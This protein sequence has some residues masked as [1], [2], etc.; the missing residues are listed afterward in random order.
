MRPS[1]RKTDGVSSLF[2]SSW[3][4]EEEVGVRLVEF[5]NNL[6][7]FEIPDLDGVLGTSAEPVG[8]GGEAEGVDDGSSF[9]RVQVLALVEIPEHGSVVLTTR[10]TERSVRRNG[11]G[12]DVS[13]VSLEVG[14]QLAGGQVP[15]LN[16]LIPTRRHDDGAAGDGREA[17]TA[18]P[19]GVSLVGQ[20]E[21]ALSE[22]VPELDGLVSG[23]GDDL[24]VVSGEGHGQNI[25][26]VS[27]ESSSG[28]GMLQIPE[29]ESTIPGSRKSKISITAHHD[30]L[31][32]VGVTRETLVGLSIAAWLVSGDVG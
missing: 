21:L 14:G 4:V 20:S 27:D 2:R 13:L 6:L 29:A 18:D 7:G 5:A 15:D 16:L 10:G 31:D 8:G 22:G 17:N 19:V 1:E 11:D 30:I 3:V 25:G 24:T 28:G 12:V 26:F 23:T 32:K 9:Q